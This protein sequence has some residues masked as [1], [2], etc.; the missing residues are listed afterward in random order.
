MAYD[1]AGGKI[2]LFG[3]ADLLTSYNDTW[4]WSGLVW[5]EAQAQ[6]APGPTRP[7]A[8]ECLTLA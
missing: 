2:V 8:R 7:S 5:V 4:E 1:V 6:G 3:G